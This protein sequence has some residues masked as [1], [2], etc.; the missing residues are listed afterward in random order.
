VSDRGEETGC[1]WVFARQE[2]I[3]LFGEEGDQKPK[4]TPGNNILLTKK[5]IGEGHFGGEPV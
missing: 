3:C 2:A 1:T 5:K 4:K